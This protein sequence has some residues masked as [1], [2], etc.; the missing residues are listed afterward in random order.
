M[1]FIAEPKFQST[2]SFHTLPQGQEVLGRVF[3]ANITFNE[4][5]AVLSD[6]VLAERRK[7]LSG[8]EILVLKGAWHD[9]EYEELANNS[10]YSLNYLQR[11]VAPPLWDLLSK[12]LGNGEKIGKKNLRYFL[13][14][15]TKKYLE[16]NLTNKDQISISNKSVSNKSVQLL[17][18]R[19]PDVSTFYGRTKELALLKELTIKQRCILLVGIA[20]I[21][22]T[23]LA[24]KLIAE[25]SAEATQNFDY[26][27]WKSVAHAPLFEDFIYEILEIVQ[28]LEHQTISRES[29]Q[30]MISLLIK[31]LQSHRC[32][33][34]LDTFDALLQKNNF[35]QRLDYRLFFRRLAEEVSQSCI[36]LT[37]RI[38]PDEI[39]ILITAE[40]PINFIRLEGLETD[41]ALQLLSS[42]G[43]T[44]K[45][46]CNELIKTYRG[47]PSELK[48]VV[49]RIHHF[50]ASSTEK[51]FETPTTLVSDQFREMLNQIFRQ[52]ILTA[53]Q[54]E[55]MI[56]LAE[57]LTLNLNSVS[58]AKLLFDMGHKHK[59][60][61][62]TSE[63]IKGLEGLEKDS[64][65]ESIKD[66]ITKEISFTLQPVIKK[67]IKTD[68]L[69]LVHSSDTSSQIAIA[70]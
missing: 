15:V 18:S 58:F 1:D 9:D 46:K 4:A 20:G 57:E 14:Q 23:T 28:P 61:I 66:P 53:I 47:N 44:N 41:A 8:A 70:S 63:L 67:Y 37:S 10:D 22:K 33:I 13:E 34:V 69:G 26:L 51:F 43:L 64:L 25:L 2:A 3:P 62:S 39:E 52:Q 56:Y 11:R 45:E 38:F 21:G 36:L 7:C 42:K 30:V 40:L 31:F 16:Q 54:K 50:F 55:I 59:G 12:L 49:N 68:P 5:L 60:L 27:I 29:N 24:A 48:A 6:L 35:Q 32:L 19:L 17:G 65:I